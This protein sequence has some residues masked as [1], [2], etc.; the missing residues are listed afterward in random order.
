M[1]DPLHKQTI[2]V[3]GFARQGRALARWLPTIGARVV[4][5]DSKT[6]EQLGVDVAD[7]PGA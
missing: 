7:Y 3:I 1:T 5:S 6:A 4:V 2:L